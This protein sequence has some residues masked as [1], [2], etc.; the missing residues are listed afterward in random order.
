MAVVCVDVAATPVRV[1]RLLSSLLTPVVS[2]P[3][4]PTQGEGP[5]RPFCSH[6]ALPH[7]PGDEGGSSYDPYGWSKFSSTPSHTPRHLTSPSGSESG[8]AVQD[9]IAVLPATPS[10]APRSSSPP[11]TGREL[12][13]AG[14]LGLDLHYSVSYLLLRISPES[15]PTCPPGLTLWCNG[16]RLS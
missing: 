13:A 5:P 14:R 1:R 8:P 7:Q 6:V 9:R 12:G 4:P 2:R 16:S 15:G 10:L 11:P 3:L